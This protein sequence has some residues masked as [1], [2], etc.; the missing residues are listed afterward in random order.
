MKLFV[1][2]YKHNQVHKEIDLGPIDKKTAQLVL[3]FVNEYLD[4]S[5]QVFKLADS[6]QIEYEDGEAIDIHF[7]DKEDKL[8]DLLTEY[9]KNLA[10]DTLNGDMGAAF[11]FS[12]QQECRDFCQ[13]LNAIGGVDYSGY[14]LGGK[15]RVSVRFKIK[16]SQ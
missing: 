1:T 14:N 8:K 11:C 6:Y 15:Y 12:T 3:N 16:E 10:Y 2:D 4:N 5:Y 13:K 9:N 7:L